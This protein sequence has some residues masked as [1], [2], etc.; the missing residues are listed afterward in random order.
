M[1]D[2]SISSEASGDII[3]EA[4]VKQ[5]IP[6]AVVE[7][8][9]SG[10]PSRGAPSSFGGRGARGRGPGGPGRGGPGRGRGR[11]PAPA[12]EQVESNF[13]EKVVHINRCAKVVKGGRRFSF[14]ALVVVGDGAGNVGV[15]Y[16]KAK[17]VPDCIRKGTEQAKRNMQP[18]QLRGETI[19]HPVTG[20]H[21]GGRVMLRPASEGTGVIAGGGVRAVL[22]ACG[23]KNVLSKSLKSNNPSAVVFATLDA[24]KQL[25][26]AETIRK[27]RSA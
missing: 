14:A 11:G 20:D 1:S 13:I 24:L 27:I 12:E 16:G 3:R 17:E 18:I 5:N 26:S 21:D 9:A 15:G 10:A 19:P 23:V 8:P 22:E 6:S 4:P 25:R 7:M 2:K